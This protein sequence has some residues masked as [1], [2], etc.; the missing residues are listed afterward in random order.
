VLV[1]K[2]FLK[3]SGL[4]L[5]LSSTCFPLLATVSYSV[6]E[7]LLYDLRLLADHAFAPVEDFMSEQDYLSVLETGRLSTGE[8]FPIPIVLAVPS[9]I[10]EKAS[11]EGEILL[12]DEKMNPL[13]LCQIQQIYTPDVEKEALS[14]YGTLSQNHPGVRNALS[15]KGMKYIA[16]SIKPMDYLK[17]LSREEGVIT[18][19]ESKAFIL[20]NGWKKVVAF[21]T[22]NPLHNA[23]IALI[24]SALDKAG[25]DACLLL[26]PV[27]GP[28]QTEDIPARIRKKC[29]EAI[30]PLFN[31]RKVKLA[32]LPLAMR[33]A[34]PKEAL[35]HAIIRKNYGATHF[36]IGRD[37]AG[38][39][40]KDEN[41]NAFYKPYAAQQLVKSVEKELGLTILTNEEMVYASEVENYVPAST[42]S[43][44][45]T[46]NISGTE[47]RRKLS[48]DEEIP[49]W[50]SPPEVIHILRQYYRNHNG[51]CIYLLG[52]SGSGKSTIAE[53]LKKELETLDPYQREVI[54][55]DGDV[56]RKYLASELGFTK[57]D[58]SINVRRIGYVASLITKA[59]GI[60][61]CANIAP[62]DEDRLANRELI[63]KGATYFEVYVDTPIEACEQRDVKGLYKLA[64]EG[65]IKEFTGISDPFEIPTKADLVVTGTEEVSESTKKVLSNLKDKI[66]YL[67]N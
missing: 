38:P 66:H 24:Q 57:K 12:R 26:H 37:H 46:Y 51:L 11:V 43:E 25:E 16:A 20:E 59:G 1:K 56:I 17:T 13:A 18:P 44:Y 7:R 15:K 10:A 21:Q 45:T 2:I 35:L 65:K 63:S 19:E 54:I 5:L 40:S 28:T 31:S 32:Y 64:R 27:I 8:L 36:I 9:D 62:Y 4:I 6:D 14:T 22:R 48:A 42:S 49:E 50:F 34:G 55:L 47:L 52:L 3:L 67:N 58:R 60:C 39:S 53:S 41:G 29:Y 23:H 30:V 61:I 33:M